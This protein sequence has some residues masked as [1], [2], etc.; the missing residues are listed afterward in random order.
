[1]NHT[2]RDRQ[3]KN[4]LQKNNKFKVQFIHCNRQ[5]CMRGT[6]IKNKQKQVV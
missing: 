6:Y 1:M 5:S 4:F 3:N 2:Q